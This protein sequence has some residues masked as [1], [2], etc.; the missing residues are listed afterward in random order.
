[1]AGGPPFSMGQQGRRRHAA[2]REAGALLISS[3]RNVLG[4]SGFSSRCQRVQLIELSRAGSI[5]H[6]SSGVSWWRSTC[7]AR[8]ES[9]GKD[10]PG[11]F[12]PSQRAHGAAENEAGLTVS[13]SDH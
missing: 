2:R 11:R 1:M 4:S 9:L 6:E 8:F 13:R 7:S 3:A 10:S 12:S 5:I